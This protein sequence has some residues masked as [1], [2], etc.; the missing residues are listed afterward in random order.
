M[1]T[2]LDP[3]LATLRAVVDTIIP[4]DEWSGG[5]DGGVRRLIDEH[6]D[7][8]LSGLRPSLFVACDALDTTAQLR[9]GLDYAILPAAARR[10]VLDMISAE[11]QTSTAADALV[12]LAFQGFYA[13]TAA[14]AGWR[15]LGFDPGPTAASGEAYDQSTPL[16]G[17]ADDYDVIIVGA[18]GGGGVV[19]SELAARGAHV[20]V[21]ER[22]RPMRASELRSNHLQGKR[23]QAYATIAGPGPGNP[24]L[25]E[26]PDGQTVTLDGDGDGGDYGLNAMTLGGGTRLWQGMSWRFH[27]EDFAMATTYGRPEGSTLADWPIAYADLAPYYDRVEWEL[28]VS[29]DAN[30]DMARR[31]PRARPFPMPALPGDPV[32]TALS[33]S[34]STLGWRSSSIPFAINSVPRDGRPAC[35]SCGQCV[36]HACPVNAKNGTQN[37]FIPRAIAT[38]N[39]DLLMSAQVTQVVHD[40][41]GSASGVR[42]LIDTSDGT[43]ERRIRAHR[44][45]VAAGAVET[46]RLLMVSGLGNEWLGRNHHTHGIAAATALTGPRFEPRRGPGHSIATVDWVHRDGLAWGGGV[47]FDAPAMYPYTQALLG[48]AAGHR[49]GLEHKQWMRDMGSP[50]GTLSMV[51]EIPDES[52]RVG[53]D[54]RIVDRHGVPVARMRGEAHPATREAVSFMV[55]RCV[56]WLESAGGRDVL[57]T[58]LSVAPQGAE[59]SAGTARM[60]AD[61]IDGAC[62]PE[63]R[64]YGTANVF[65]ADASLHPTNGGF[66]PGLTVM[67]NAMRVAAGIDLVGAGRR[68]ERPDRARIIAET[69]AVSPGQPVGHPCPRCPE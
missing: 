50:L 37:T 30:S 20:L 34:A 25:L 56:E 59:H 36:G 53:I 23:L 52:A 48:Q 1:P 38:G 33:T 19:A 68:K 8:F 66:N 47:I 6:G 69:R 3:I 62:S 2:G 41:S 14:P 16:S 64:L 22:A 5:W 15:M 18:G 32:R 4:E 55:D 67:A 49:W 12:T 45:I 46:A 28:G 58:A 26:L 42:L 24:R 29:G 61:P 11:A 57:R 65:V 27:E 7:G 63:G 31:T 39:C 17:I 21:I 13:G 9:H 54:S 10:E 40:G 43:R 51:Q 60:A 35:V 44:I